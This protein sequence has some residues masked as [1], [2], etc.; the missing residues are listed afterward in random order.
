MQKM[1]V[2]LQ[3]FSNGLEF[4]KFLELKNGDKTSL[5]HTSWVL[6]CNAMVLTGGM[7]FAQKSAEIQ[8][9]MKKKMNPFTFA[10]K[11]Q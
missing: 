11:V 5:P 9:S 4:S 8:K 7:D 2:Q 3:I 6:Y 10:G 1:L